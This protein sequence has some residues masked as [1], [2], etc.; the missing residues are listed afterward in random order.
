MFDF[1]LPQFLFLLIAS[2]A[3]A[4]GASRSFGADAGVLS[5]ERAPHP[6]GVHLRPLAAAHPVNLARTNGAR[7][8]RRRRVGGGSV[9]E[10]C[11]ALQKLHTPLICGHR[12]DVIG[13]NA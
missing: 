3:C 2:L 11:F 4:W 6:G 9:A 5:G 7:R 10:T 12:S 1:S 8:R 13:R